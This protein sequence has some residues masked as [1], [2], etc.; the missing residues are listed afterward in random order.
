MSYRLVL[1]VVVA[2]F[3]VVVLV[4]VAVV[5]ALQ[6]LLARLYES[7]IPLQGTRHTGWW[8]GVVGNSFRLK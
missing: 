6:S 5:V 2:I 3:V 4:V 1:V 8:R 7:T